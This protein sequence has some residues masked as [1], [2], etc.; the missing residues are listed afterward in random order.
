MIR[1]IRYTI[2]LSHV[3]SANNPQF[4]NRCLLKWYFF[5]GRYCIIKQIFSKNSNHLNLK[6]HFIYFM[7]SVVSQMPLQIRLKIIQLMCK[8]PTNLPS[9][10]VFYLMFRNLNNLRLFSS[11][12]NFCFLDIYLELHSIYLRLLEMLG[13]HVFFFYCPGGWYSPGS[14]FVKIMWLWAYSSLVCS[15]F[16]GISPVMNPPELL[17]F[18]EIPTCAMELAALNKTKK[19]AKS[20]QHS[21]SVIFKF[22]FFFHC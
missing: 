5:A 2:I 3:H 14:A 19:T 16:L 9:V 20:L 22:N 15:V 10:W 11:Q 1:F 6:Q 7:W 18:V 21:L 13:E 4:G 8:H 17:S 12:F